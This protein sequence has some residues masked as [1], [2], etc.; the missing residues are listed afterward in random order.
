MRISPTLLLTVALS[1]TLSLP[2]GSSAAPQNLTETDFKRWTETFQKAGTSTGMMGMAVAVIHNGKTI[3]A[4]AFGKRNDKDPFTLETVGNIASLTKAFTAAACGELV[5]EGKAD[6]NTPVNEYVPEFKSKN[7]HMTADLTLIDLLSHRSGYPMLDLHWFHRTES[8]SELIK[9]LRHVEPVAPIRTKWIYNNIMYA[10][11]GEASA[12]IEGK[13]W[14]DVVRD[15]IFI[16]AGMTYSGFSTKKMI[17]T[18]NHAR[19]TWAKSF[20]AAQRG[21][22]LIIPPDTFTLADAPA[23]DIYSNVIDLAKWAKL[24]LREGKLDGKQVLHKETITTSHTG[25]MAVDGVTYGLGWTIENY[26]GHRMINHAGANPGFRNQLTLF[27]DDD[28]AII[29]LSNKE[30]NDIVAHLPLW[31]ADYI[32]NL[33]TTRDWLGKDLLAADKRV[34]S[35]RTPEALESFF[36]PQVKNKP[37]T[38]KLADFAGEWRHPYGPALSLV[39]KGK[40]NKATLQFKMTAYEGTLE[41]YHYDSFHARLNHPGLIT[42]VLLSFVTGNGG[43]ADQLRF[44]TSDETMVYTRAASA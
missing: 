6:W 42:T 10:V 44:T 15:K 29:V 30:V 8:R 24:L 3:Y 11:A 16:P 37:P 14:E 39:L 22:N 1:V 2:G 38:R 32:F 41:H 40:G 20:E 25:W 21:E 19:G 17:T 9:Q 13:S 23:G 43:D 28:L 12:R 35:W 36:P 4:K 26:K 34:Y 27:P 31:L 33:P 7:P 5:A 18:P